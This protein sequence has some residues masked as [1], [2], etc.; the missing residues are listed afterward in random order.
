M[1]YRSTISEQL[2]EKMH[3]LKNCR[4]YESFKLSTYDVRVDSCH[5]FSCYMYD[6][7]SYLQHG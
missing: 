1:H 6:T 5:H 4:A 7:H 2:N 3:N